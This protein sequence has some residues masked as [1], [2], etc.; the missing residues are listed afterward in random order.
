MRNL[1]EVGL[2]NAAATYNGKPVLIAKTGA[3]YH[4]RQEQRAAGDAAAAGGGDAAGDGAVSFLE[5]DINVHRFSYPARAGLQ[6]I[7]GRFCEMEMAV[8]FVIE[9]RSDVELPEVMLGAA[10]LNRCDW[11]SAVAL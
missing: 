5:M 2:P 6:S 1:D 8:G 9:G 4:E 7:F 3:L 10:Q 11:E